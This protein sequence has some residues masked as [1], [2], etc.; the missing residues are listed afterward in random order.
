MTER[1][2]SGRTR[3]LAGTRLHTWRRWFGDPSGGGYG[4]RPSTDIYEVDGGVLV[5]VEIAGL[6]GGDFTIACDERRLSVSGERRGTGTGG[7]GRKPLSCHLVEIAAGRF[8][9]DIELP[10]A[11]DS[12]GLE[13]EY[14]DGI[15]S[16]YLPRARNASG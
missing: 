4:W 9:T 15:V 10:L 6:T 14:A 5:Q 1:S 2:S 16:I 11:V 12:Q 13:V 3:D 8:R 7:T